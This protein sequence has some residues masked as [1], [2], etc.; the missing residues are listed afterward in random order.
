M[1]DLCG[2]LIGTAI[3]GKPAVG[4]MR[5]DM[6]ESVPFEG[7]M[8]TIGICV[9]HL[10]QAIPIWRDPP[11]LETTDAPP[12]ETTVLNKGRQRN[13]LHTTPA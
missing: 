6:R 13:Y 3:C 11:P 12:L 10:R 8:I 4:S 2:I 9:A 5:I 1:T 7:T